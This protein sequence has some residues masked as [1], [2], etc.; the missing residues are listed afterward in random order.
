MKTLNF[1][2]LGLG[3][4]LIGLFFA[5]TVCAQDEYLSEEE[6]FG[7][8][9]LNGGGIS[10]PLESINRA[11]FQFNDFLYL[12]VFDPIG[13]VYSAITPDPV[14]QGATNFFQ[15]LKY[16]VRLVGNLLQ[17]R[18]AGAWTETERFLLNST[19]GVA[20]TM[21]PSDSYE[22]L[23]PIPSE[24]I[25]QALGSW[26]I[27]NGPY[28]VLPIFGPSTLRDLVGFVGD[29]A[30]NPLQEPF[31][32][33]DDWEWE[34]QFALT[35]SEVVTGLSSQTARYRQMKGSSIDGY[36]AL[37]NGYTQFRRAAVAE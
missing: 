25:G 21:R 5:A 6:L 3:L 24:D 35:A 14:E 28:L 11:I 16:P 10:D 37:K 12:Q 26:G 27:G 15:N 22:R 19:V 30:V 18:F 1:K 20:G 17:G 29:R 4:G 34:E 33:I 7:E 31:S 32:A 2:F 8:D 9:V 36:G 13:Q 23:A